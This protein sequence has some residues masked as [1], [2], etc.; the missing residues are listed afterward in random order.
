M[1][2]PNDPKAFKGQP[3]ILFDTIVARSFLLGDNT[4]G[5]AVG[6]QVPAVSA[7]GEIVFFQSSGRTKANMPWYTNLD[8]AGQLA[9]GLEV[10]QIYLAIQFPTWPPVGST[11]ANTDTDAV[12]I[13]PPTLKLAEAIINFGVLELNLGQEE[14]TVWP[15]SR[16]GAGGGLSGNNFLNAIA[17]NSLP[18]GANVMKLPEPIQMGRTQN[19]SAKIRLAPEAFAMIGSPAAPGVGSPLDPYE[20]NTEQGEAPVLVSLAE[21]PFS[22][23]LGLVGRRIKMTQYGQIAQ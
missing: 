2:Q 13:V 17:Q 10:W 5:L 11:S 21:L 7:S 3:W 8:I 20:Y 23:Q 12:N 18:Q 15:V 19:L 9:Y 1:E 6:G 14:Q 22:I 16:F 4:N